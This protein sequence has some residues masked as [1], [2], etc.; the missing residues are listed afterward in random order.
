MIEIDLEA[1]NGCGICVKDCPLGV[2]DL[3]DKKA[4]VG[5]GCV[6]CLTCQKVC[7]PAA[8][9]V[10]EAPLAPGVVLC[11]A[12]PVA[13]RVPPRRTGACRR[14]VNEKGRLVRSRPLLGYDEVQGEVGPFPRPEIAT[15]LITAIGAGGTYPDYVPAPHIV[16]HRRGEVDVVTAV[17]EAPLSYSGLK[18]K[19]DTDAHLGD[20]GSVVTFE[21]RP[22]GMVETEEYGSKIIALGGV[23]RLTGK[24]GVAAARAVAAAA[25]R[26][27]IRLKVR[28]GPGLEV[29]VGRPP[30]I[31][32][33]R[34]GRM[35]VGCGSAT[36]GLFAPFLKRA[37]DE[38]IVLDAHI[39]SLFTHHAAGRCLG[40]EPSGIELTYPKSTPGRYFGRAGQ[41][42]GAT[43]VE[44]PLDVIAAVDRAK[45]PVGFRLLVTE[46]TGQKA[47]LFEFGA[48][49]IFGE[50]EP[51]PEVAEAVA[52][53]AETCQMSR[54][55]A[56]YV[57]GAGGSARAGVTRYPLRLTKAVHD[58]RAVLTVG[59]APV[60]IL[61]GGGITFYVDVEKVRV[62]AFTW[63]P[64][65]ATVCPL[66]YTMTREDYE[67]MGGHQEAMKP[68]TA[69]KPKEWNR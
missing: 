45:I 52:A 55:S 24:Y 63:V 42:W 12:C 6:E 31:D 2:I 4:V 9:L 37:A 65:P 20:E 29:Q 35:R 43:D 19:I 14:F 64:T 16:T 67:A 5:E 58:R 8:V 69:L 36:A 27:A 47:A 18:L 59:G 57:G 22:V 26:E 50:I 34:M 13:C 51:T 23:N 46:T 21:G 56:V 7:P 41:G 33:A 11:E 66:E 60:F 17:T 61:P 25:N 10:R 32:G 48:D 15:P 68:F 3:E 28:G 54:V 38:V 62:G 53:I 44:R 30:V 39:T 40:S 49:G 1:C